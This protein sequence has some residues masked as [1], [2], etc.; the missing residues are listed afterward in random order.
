MPR[1]DKKSVLLRQI[2]LL[3]LLPT[4]GASKTAT[5]LTRALNDAGF[6]ITKRQVERDLNELMEAFTLDRNDSS[7]PHGWKWV[8]G[9]SVDLPGMTITEA[10]SLRLVEDTLKPLMPVSMLEGLETRFRQAEKQLLALGKEN[11][12]AKWASKVRTVTPAMPLMPPEIDSAVLATVQEAL[13]SDVQVEIDYQ[14]MRDETDKKML[15]SPLA[16]VNR[17]TVTYLVATAFEYEDVRLYAMNRIHNATRTDNAVKRPANF[18]LDEYIQVG[19]MH[20]GHGKTIRL[21]AWVSPVLAK[22]LEETPMSEDQHLTTVDGEIKLSATVSDSWQLKWWLL[23]QGAGI[24]VTSPVALRKKIGSVLLEA[25][26]QYASEFARFELTHK[27]D[28]ML[29]DWM[30]GV[31]QRAAKIQEE[32]E[33]G[34]H[35][36]LEKKIGSRQPTEKEDGFLEQLKRPLPRPLPYYGPI[37]GGISITFTPTGLDVICRVTEAITGETIDLTDYDSF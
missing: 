34:R 36:S 14:A 6:N 27:Q 26:N 11:R 8:A 9:A 28:E 22:L 31:A 33:G 5:Q 13:L 2:E 25:G 17:G 16:L 7:I 35:L 10:L 23:S 19:G 18:D 1:N 30:V 12:N 32:G 29:K 4:R 37:G 24:E 3:K 15:L 20:F 21:K